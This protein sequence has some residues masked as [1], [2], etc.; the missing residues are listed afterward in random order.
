MHM[1]LCPYCTGTADSGREMLDHIGEAHPAMA[2]ILLCGT[3]WL[4]AIL[5][6]P[7]HDCARLLQSD[8]RGRD[9]APGHRDDPAWHAH[10]RQ[11]RDLASRLV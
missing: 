3:C 1:E 8:C 7:Q 5:G 6:H 4:P 2:R 10:T 11:L 9:H